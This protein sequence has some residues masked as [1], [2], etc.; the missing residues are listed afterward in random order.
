MLDIILIAPNIGSVSPNYEFIISQV[1]N[2]KIKLI[3]RR[4]FVLAL[5]KTTRKNLHTLILK[6]KIRV[7]LIV[8]L[9]LGFRLWTSSLPTY[10]TYSLS[11]EGFLCFY[12]INI[13]SFFSNLGYTFVVLSGNKLFLYPSY[14]A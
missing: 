1:I 10:E 14:L 7:S 9:N 2:M 12:Q 13:Q 3:W 6:E 11:V 8:L 4:G 5:N